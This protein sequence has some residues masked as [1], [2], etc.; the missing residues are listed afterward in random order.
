[1]T[2]CDE[3]FT[4]AVDP[5]ATGVKVYPLIATITHE[6]KAKKGRT[7]TV[8]IPFDVKSFMYQSPTAF[9]GGGSQ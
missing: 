9:N 3:A 1:V 6:G 4:L 5:T 2:T 7:T 8:R